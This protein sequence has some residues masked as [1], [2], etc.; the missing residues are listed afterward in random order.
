MVLNTSQTW[1]Q[2]RP[3]EIRTNCG[4]CHAHSQ[5]P[6][7]FALTAAA[8]QEYLVWD[9]VNSTPLVTTKA[10]DGSKQKWDVAD[11]AGLRMAAARP[12]DVEYWRDIKPILERS[13]TACHTRQSPEPAGNLVLDADDELIPLEQKG[14]FPGTYYR[15]ALDEGAKFGHGPLATIRGLSKCLSLHPQD[16][17]ATF[18]PRLENL[19]RTP[20]RLLE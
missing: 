20:R 8:R 12:A 19:R 2:L 4:G 7:D 1:H 10:N 16:A 6:T 3:G 14:K 13:C 11:S 9:L 17:V 15:L 5:A 18:T